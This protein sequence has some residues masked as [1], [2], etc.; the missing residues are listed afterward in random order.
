MQDV[1]KDNKGILEVMKMK[2]WQDGKVELNSLV[3]SYTTGKDHILDQELVK[4]D[5]FGSLAHASMLYE[6]GVF[7]EDEFKI[8]KKELKNILELDEKSEFD[9][10]LSD[11]DVHSKIE[12][13]LVEKLGDVGKKIHTG[14]SRND[15]VL[16]DMRLY[17][18]DRLLEIKKEL[19][20]LCKALIK[21]S[22]EHR[23]VP[24]PGYTHMRKA[25]I[26]SVGLWGGS[27][28]ESLL[29][30][31]EYL[32]SVYDT[33]NQNPLGSAAG[34]GVPLPLD[35]DFTTNLLG[36]RKTQNNVMY[37]QNSR[38][39]IELG[40]LDALKQIML[41][42]NK[43]ATDVLLFSIEGI[44]YFSLPD[45]LCTGS[46]IM[47]QKNNP[48][49]LELVRAN[50]NILLGESNKVSNVLGSLPSGY[51]RDYQLTKEPLMHGLEITLSTISVC[52]L[53][54]SDIIVNESNIRD[55]ITPSLFATDQV[56][57]LTSKGIPFR[58]AYREFKNSNRWS[59]ID[60]GKTFE[61]KKYKGAP[62]NIGLDPLK[63][64]VLKKE[65]C[66]LEERKKIRSVFDD[67][68]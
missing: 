40:I 53:V 68:L 67:L 11:E 36:F 3:E 12:T 2:L 27:F 5:V 41:D 32:D 16:V 44:E 43:F 13:H 14:R 52:R 18:R 29:D 62:G 48:D 54:V 8:V 56:F 6:I 50:Y 31:L 55:S 17:S 65:K 4:F 57:E 26:S 30:D 37:V 45:E 59:S 19:L 51:N 24:M 66:V 20:D 34:Y 28:I 64:K 7:D 21:F 23:S 47:P 25:M 46:S 39:K 9:I 63:E 10:S 42:L 38:G 22:G 49:I 58:D 35:R 60:A 15:Q 33:N 61:S 1:S